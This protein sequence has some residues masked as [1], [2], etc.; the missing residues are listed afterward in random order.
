MRVQ[1]AIVVALLCCAGISYAQQGLVGSYYGEYPE[2][3]GHGWPKIQG[4]TLK[5][6]SAKDGKIA[7]QLV[8]GSNECVGNYELEGSYQ[9]NKLEMK[10][11]EGSLRGCGQQPVTL[12]VQGDKLVGR[13]GMFSVQLT[14]K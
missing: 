10:T 9:D 14:R 8:L 12:E 6:V 13:Y 3:T 7:G 11:S 1:A 4:L 5:I 2:P